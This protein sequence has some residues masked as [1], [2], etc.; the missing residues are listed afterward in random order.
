MKK[1][2]HEYKCAIS[3]SYQ[4]R[5]LLLGANGANIRICEFCSNVHYNWPCFDTILYKTNTGTLMVIR[6][7]LAQCVD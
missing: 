4:Q 1:N 6:C 2:A 5:E 7:A 3:F